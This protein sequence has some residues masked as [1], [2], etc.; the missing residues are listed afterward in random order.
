MNDSLCASLLHP[1]V[2]WM[3][4]GGE[5]RSS[6]APAANCAA[7]FIHGI[8]SCLSIHIFVA[9]PTLANVANALLIAGCSRHPS[10]CFG[11]CE[12][13]WFLDVGRAVHFVLYGILAGGRAVA[14]R[15]WIIQGKVYGLYDRAVDVLVSA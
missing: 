13:V 8:L 12:R 9:I 10:N 11:A 4:N 7:V 14:R 6:Q 1:S 3:K 5:T 15:C 2:I